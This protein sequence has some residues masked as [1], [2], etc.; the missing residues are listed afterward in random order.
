MVKSGLDEIKK[1]LK[2]KKLVIGTDSAIKNLKLK[3]LSTIFVSSNAPKEIMGDVEHYAKLSG[4]EVVKL[5]V[6]NDELG[7]QCK[8]PY[9]I[10]I[11]GLL[12]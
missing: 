3:R 9:S 5:D 6:P 4:T 8:K 2:T 11:I 10:S 7:V 12:A 1:N